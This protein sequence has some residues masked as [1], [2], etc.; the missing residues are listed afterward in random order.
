[1]ARRLTVFENRQ[2]AIA[3][4]V[5]LVQRKGQRVLGRDRLGTGGHHVLD[6][7]FGKRGG[8]PRKFFE[9]VALAEDVGPLAVG[10]EEEDSPE[11][12]GEHDLNGLLETGRRS[13]GDGGARVQV[14]DRIFHEAALDPVLR[15]GTVPVAEVLLAVAA[16]LHTGEVVPAAGWT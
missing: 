13:N 16:F 8:Q 4:N 12:V 5:H 3:A 6:S 2:V 11:V 15:D 9:Q 1:D 14:A 10:T 7:K